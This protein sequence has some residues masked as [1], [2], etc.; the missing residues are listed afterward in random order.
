MLLFPLPQQTTETLF[1]IAID[2]L[3]SI[4]D[5]KSSLWAKGYAHWVQAGL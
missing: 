5:Q 2:A 4:P 3:S 1:L